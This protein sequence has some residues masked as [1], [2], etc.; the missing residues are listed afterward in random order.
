MPSKQ[1]LKEF[2]TSAELTPLTRELD[3]DLFYEYYRKGALGA[4][5]L[6]IPGGMKIKVELD[7]LFEHV[8]NLKSFENRTTPENIEAICVYGSAL[9]KHF[10]EEET[11]TQERKKYL[12]FG[13]KEV[14]TQ[15]VTRYKIP[16]DFDVLVILKDGLTDDK[17]VVP[18]RTTT[19]VDT[20][21]GYVE[22]RVES[23]GTSGVL[24]Q[25]PV[26]GDYG[27][28]ESYVRG[29]DLDL[30]ICYR[31]VEQFLAGLGQGDELSESVV[32]YG[33]PVAGKGRFEILV[34][35]VNRERSPL[36]SVNLFE[37]SQG[38]LQ[39]KIK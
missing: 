8:T 28:I 36:H 25:H 22:R 15:T 6:T 27:Y 10:G 2:P 11:L 29:G 13:P 33:V 39:I 20:G 7:K 9:Y 14:K 37:D 12:L 19:N 1:M 18:V 24:T 26:V 30:H 35:S 34:N 5:E 17:I 4:I 38:K 32:S 31:S 3:A 23:D 21:Y 16:R